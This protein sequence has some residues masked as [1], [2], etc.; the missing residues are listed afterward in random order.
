MELTSAELQ[1]KLTYFKRGGKYVTEGVFSQVF[2]DCRLLLDGSI[3]AYMPEICERV[4]VKS[5]FAD[6]PGLNSGVF[7][8]GHILV[9]CEQGYPC[10]LEAPLLMTQEE[11]NARP[12]ALIRVGGKNFRCDCGCNVFKRY[13]KTAYCCNGCE[14]IWREG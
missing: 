13:D 14:A 6:L 4:R 12:D 5:I 7:E 9:D 11:K 1:V 10:L 2:N 3:Q 8:E